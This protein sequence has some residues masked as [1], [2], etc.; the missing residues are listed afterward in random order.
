MEIA[1]THPAQGYMGIWMDS[2]MLHCQAAHSKWS[3]QTLAKEPNRNEQDAN[4]RS[5]IWKRQRLINL[6]QYIARSAPLAG[7]IAACLSAA[8]HRCNGGLKLKCTQGVPACS[9]QGQQK[10]GVY[11]KAIVMQGLFRDAGW[12]G[13]RQGRRGMWSCNLMQIAS[14]ELPGMA[15]KAKAL[16]GLIRTADDRS[17]KEVS[18]CEWR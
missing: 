3:R 17:M 15:C 11:E 14:S 4:E 13:Q 9:G 8:M 18:G 1:Q 10:S 7:T 6:P 5:G 16:Q 2:G 12:C